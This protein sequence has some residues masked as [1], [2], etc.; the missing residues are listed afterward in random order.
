[1]FQ[2]TSPPVAIAPRLAYT[3][4][5]PAG[6]WTDGQQVT[7]N[8][9]GVG[10]T[11]SASINA[12]LIIPNQSW[13]IKD[14][15]SF[16]V[17]NLPTPS[18]P[19]DAANKAYVDA[20]A[21]GGGGGTP[22]GTSGQIQFN[23]ASVFGG[24]TMSGDATINTGTGVMTLSPSGTLINYALL[25]SPT[26]T[27]T[28][29]GPTA[30]AGTSTTQ[31]A[32]TAFVGTAITNAA[33]PPASTA[34]PA[35][36]G[37]GAAG[38]AT[39]YSR[40]DHV[41]PTD[42]S[43]APL[44][45]PTFTG[46]PAAPTAAVDTNTTQLATTAYVIAQA[47]A[48][49]DGTPAMDGTATRGTSTHWA[50]A[51]HVHPTD[52]SRAPLASPAL[53]GTPTSTTPATVDNS[54]NIATTAFVKAQSYLIGNQT[55]TLSG[56]VTGSGTTAIT[57]TIAAGVVTNAMHVNM[58]ALTIK[59]NNTGSS[60]APIDLT[61][62]Q[63]TAMLNA[64]T[65][66]GT[67]HLQ[68]LVPDP[69][70]TAGTTKFLREDATWVAALTGNQTI[71]L[72]GDVSGSGTTAITT[73][74]GNA[75]VTYAKMQNVAASRLLG[76]P[77]GSA[78]APSEI[79]L[80]AALAFSGTALQTAAM[81]GDITTSTNSFATTLATV[82]SNVGT[83]Q[84]ITV[85]GKGLVTA[86]ANQNYAPL[87]SP[88]FTGTV[89]IPTLAITTAGTSVTPATADN[90]TNVATTA[91][92]K[93]QGY[94]TSSTV[95]VS[96]TAP[97]SPSAGAMWWNST[98]GNLFVYYNDGTSSQWVFA[99]SAA[100]TNVVRAYLSGLTLS[101][102]G[103]STTFSVAPGTC[104]DDT[105]VDMMVLASSISKTT[106]AWA[107][108]SANGGLDTGSISVSTWYHAYLIKR[109]DTGV[110]DVLFSL[111]ATSPTM[112]TNYTE[113]RRIGSIRT[114]TSS[115]WRLFHQIGD[116]F[117][118]DAWN[119]DATSVA[120]ATTASLVTLMVPLGIQVRALF[121]GR[122]DGTTAGSIIFS[123]PDISDQSPANPLTSLACS[124]TASTAIGQFITRT[125]TSSRVR[126]RANATG[127]TYGIGTYGWIDTRGR[128]A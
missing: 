97:A 30:T 42:T 33:V 77:T 117:L 124:S 28:P 123:S 54:T 49:G 48:V 56:N 55:I 41:H 78:A 34:T 82:N 66:S 39:A 25:A 128:D 106:G 122:L 45:S 93:A 4:Y 63:T 6:P 40:G 44:A 5:T 35:M 85:N 74:I 104:A 3:D 26:F 73:T 98:T 105:N 1:M 9:D 83:F 75:A 37:T 8:S 107:V 103:S 119:G 2:S 14:A 118:W 102:A 21:G 19:G 79:S 84:G 116:E 72:S 67:G 10:F 80:G 69:G 62:A 99:S 38:S 112:P 57:T 11:Y 126:V 29:A 109:I 114:D 58:N 110:I 59:G 90:S 101:T 127:N 52:T 7:R 91:F 120:T 36:D 53:T 86:A 87:A 113:K 70:S 12:L 95:T 92:V 31:L 22:G 88:T 47:S 60:A 89:T 13:S 17:E 50:R 108:G 32:T 96:D 16:I 46:T 125:D 27:G 18:N 65:A 81:T 111:S 94:L 100:A 51:D 23:N 61:A 115:N 76:N 68:G 24:F 15:N 121:S 43:R 64:F 20:H 71:T